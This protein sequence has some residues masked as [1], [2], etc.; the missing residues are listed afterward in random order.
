MPVVAD[1]G[2]SLGSASIV[3]IRLSKRSLVHAMLI[4]TKA[5]GLGWF[6]HP[7]GILAEHP[8]LRFPASCMAWW[9]RQPYAQKRSGDTR[10][11]AFEASQRNLFLCYS[12]HNSA[13]DMTSKSHWM[14]QSTLPSNIQDYSRAGSFVHGILQARTLEWVASLFSRGSSQ[15][16]YRTQVCCIASRFFTV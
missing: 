11:Q 8:G 10:R 2:P 12:P 15:P 1:V 4:M 7:L 6:N 9:I 14:S 16:R 3:F 13:L 5:E